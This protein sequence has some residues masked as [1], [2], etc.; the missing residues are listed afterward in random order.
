MQQI[1]NRYL[2][3][4]TFAIFNFCINTKSISNT[5]TLFLFFRYVN[6]FNQ[7]RNTCQKIFKVCYNF[8]SFHA[9][10]YSEKSQFIVMHIRSFISASCNKHG[11]FYRCSIQVYINICNIIEIH[12]INPYFSLLEAKYLTFT[13]ILSWDITYCT[14]RLYNQIVQPDSRKGRY[15][16]NK[17]LRL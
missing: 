5:K 10:L 6:V 4:V 12:G 15:S 8:F 14:T 3:L 7:F 13:N 11:H 9:F 2:Y 1:G 16:L 17:L